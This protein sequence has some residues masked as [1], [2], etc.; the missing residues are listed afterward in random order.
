[1]RWLTP[2]RQ[3]LDWRG[4]RLGSL[5]I[6]NDERRREFGLRIDLPRQP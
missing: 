5:N 4:V 3:D 6:F 2:P 1:M